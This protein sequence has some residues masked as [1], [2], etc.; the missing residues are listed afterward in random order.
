ML[1]F[2]IRFTYSSASWA[3][4]LKF[5]EDRAAA[6]AALL[7]HLH[8]SLEAIYWEVETASAHVTA[9]LPDS[10]SAA[11]VIT[12]ATRTGAFKEIQVSEVLTQDQ[13][14]DMVALAQSSEGIYRPPGLA[15]V[16]RDA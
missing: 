11:A 12:A 10:V 2:V 6:V 8:G 9:D 5:P 13:L 16:A 7:E 14:R 1:K 15:G 3:R 4:M